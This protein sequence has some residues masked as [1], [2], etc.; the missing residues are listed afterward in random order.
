[1][2]DDIAD[3]ENKG[4]SVHFNKRPSLHLTLVD[5][6]AS[7]RL[8][9][10]I[11]A[12]LHLYALQCRLLVQ[13]DLAPNRC[14]NWRRLLAMQCKCLK[15]MDPCSL[16]HRW[17]LPAK[18]SVWVSGSYTHSLCGHIAPHLMQYVSITSKRRPQT[19]RALPSKT[20]FI[21]DRTCNLYTRCSSP[22]NMPQRKCPVKC[23]W[24][25]SF[26][27]NERLQRIAAVPKVCKYHGVHIL[28][29]ILLQRNH[30]K[31]WAIAKICSSQ[32]C[33]SVKLLEDIH[34]NVMA[35]FMLY[36]QNTN[37]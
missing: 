35:R 25:F 20:T 29:L 23:A 6:E 24:P 19:S 13:F 11:C 26:H 9:H 37:A 4:S 28:N 17:R 34:E 32:S 8:T 30:L 1:M 5:G 27:R 2:L 21:G 36:L 12:R 3:L 33:K 7:S 22:A 31:S 18:H 16:S 15:A 10:F 14:C